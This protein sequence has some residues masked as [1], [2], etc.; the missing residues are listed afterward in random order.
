MNEIL[1]T[2]MQAVQEFGF[3]LVVAIWALWRLDRN[4][5]KGESI[6]LRLDQIDE[7]LDR[8]ELA[9]TKQAEIQQELLITIRLQTQLLHNNNN[10]NGGGNR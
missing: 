6:Q 2:I 1:K 8:I 10:N 3:P 9:M 4:W 5:A 7:S